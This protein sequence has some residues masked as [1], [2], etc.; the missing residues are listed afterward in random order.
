M[1]DSLRRLDKALRTGTGRVVAVLGS[2]AITA[3]LILLPALHSPLTVTPL[4]TLSTLAL[5]R[6]FPKVTVIMHQTPLYYD[7][8]C[9]KANQTAFAAMSA[10]TMALLLA[11]VLNYAMFRFSHSSLGLFEQVGMAGGMLSIYSK[12]HELIGKA[13]LRHLY[14]KKHPRPV[15]QLVRY[16]CS[17]AVT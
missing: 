17:S 4:A 14:R 1:L 10:I 9:D 15:V 5:C 16:P 11:A 8:L 6:A 3:S 7:D 12:A 13:L 2:V